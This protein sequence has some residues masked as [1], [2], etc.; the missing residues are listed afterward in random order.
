MQERM[1]V[2]HVQPQQFRLLTILR[3]LCFLIHTF[4]IHINDKMTHFPESGFRF[5]M[6]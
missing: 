3:N 2:L 4:I 6:C 5:H 1:K